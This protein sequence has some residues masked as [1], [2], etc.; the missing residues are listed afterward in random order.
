VYAASG[1]GKTRFGTDLL[2]LLHRKAE[3][4]AQS[5]ESMLKFSGL[6]SPK[7]EL[8]IM[9]NLIKSGKW[10]YVDFSD[11]DAP[12]FNSIS[13]DT[14]LWLILLKL[15]SPATVFSHTQAPEYKTNILWNLIQCELKASPTTPVLLE[16]HI[17]EFQKAISQS[18]LQT[19]LTNKNLEYFAH[20]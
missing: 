10:V 17:D 7:S 19:Y 9:T 14:I 5:L 12:D 8:K 6:D 3:T 2:P 16:L 18:D 11:G 15:I 4:D 20:N 13:I 1:V